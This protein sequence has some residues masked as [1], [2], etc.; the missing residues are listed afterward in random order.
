MAALEELASYLAAAVPLVG[1]QGALP[2][3][4]LTAVAE[5]LAREEQA[6]RARG[7]HHMA[8]VAAELQA[9]FV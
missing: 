5:G 1:G 4:E 9:R 6:L 8:R 2:A 3:K 7:A